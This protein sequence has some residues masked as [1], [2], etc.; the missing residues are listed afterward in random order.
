MKNNLLDVFNIPKKA[1]P[2]KILSD[3]EIF[4]DK[5]LLEAL[6]TKIVENIIDKQANNTDITSEYILD[7]VNKTLEGYNLTNLEKNH[8][9]N[10][11]EN[12]INGYG[13]LTSLLEDDNITEI[14]V[15]SP[16]EIFIEVDGQ[17]IKDESVSFINEEHIIRTIEKMIQ[18]LGRTIDA[19]NPMIDSR[20]N[21]GERLNAV[22]PPLAVN[23]PVM[24]IRKSHHDEQTIE[25]LIGKGVMTPWMARFLE[26]AI[27][28]HLNIIVCGPSG[29]GKTELLNILSE[30]IDH[31]ER[32]ITIEDAKELAL[33]QPN[34][35][36]LETKEDL[37]NHENS[38]TIRDL[39]INALR[40][41]PDRIIVGEVR[42][43]EAFDM[44]QAMNT[45]H[46]GSLTTMH[47]SSA[48]DALNRLETMVLMSGMNI[49]IKAIREYISRAIDIIINIE[50]MSDGK[51]KITSIC[52]IKGMDN[53]RIVLDDIFTF[54]LKGVTA[55]NEVDGEFALV[56]NNPKVY[57]KIKMYFPDLL[58][59]IFEGV[60]PKPNSKPQVPVQPLVKN[61]GSKKKKGK[62]NPNQPSVQPKI[63]KPSVSNVIPEMP[64]LKK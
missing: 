37:Y 59:D 62:K 15:N 11:I 38:I 41:R 60:N 49:P 56:N 50:R 30:F 13:P 55:L 57:S 61:E 16:K 1:I 3:Y 8:I 53:D 18:P 29:V 28:A 64:S 46:N 34:V 2:Q 21:N 51:R 40:M 14:M 27:K 12:E 63:N 48:Y 32:I 47:A 36:N 9:F 54:E 42:G 10:L 35:V 43:A 20:L 58:A 19:N 33:K 24:T 6:R 25:D 23:G 39:V 7:E 52:E 4:P 45:G 44:L 22:I 17:I 26:A 5:Q 31:N